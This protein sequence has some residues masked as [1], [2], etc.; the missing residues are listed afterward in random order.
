[1]VLEE[2]YLPT[3]VDTEKFQRMVDH[4]FKN[5]VI[6][7]TDDDIPLEGT[8]HCKPLHIAVLSFGYM[9]AGV[10]IDGGS[11]LNVCPYATVEDEC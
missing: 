4:I 7:F 11:S 10:L 9:L 3:S 8:G 6:S 1:M 2:A 5:N